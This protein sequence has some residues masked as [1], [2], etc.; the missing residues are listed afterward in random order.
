MKNKR[1][2]FRVY[3][4]TQKEVQVNPTKE[5]LRSKYNVSNITVMK[6]KTINSLIFTTTMQ[7][8]NNVWT[9]LKKKRGIK[10][11]WMGRT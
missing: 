7:Q 2:K 6:G 5:T 10:K 3:A 4:I 8:L 9:F 11:V 1:P